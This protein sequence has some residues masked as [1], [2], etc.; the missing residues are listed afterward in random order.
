MEELTAEE[1]VKYTIRIE[2]ESCIF[3]RKAARILEGSRFKNLFDLLADQEVEHIR[4]LQKLI[5]GK[6]IDEQ[7]LMETFYIDTSIYDNMII[8][9][10]IPVSATTDDIMKLAVKR[11]EITERTY[12]ML[13]SI[14]NL[15]P[16][17]KKLFN[18]LEKLEEKQIKELLKIKD[19]SES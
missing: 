5:E 1:I 6:T 4:Q 17:M 10:E 7:E 9:S 19:T 2:Q 14:S 11:E 18:H 15:N 3:Y 12:Q 13:T 8:T 16:R